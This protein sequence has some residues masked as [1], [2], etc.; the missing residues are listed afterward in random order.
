MKIIVI[1]ESSMSACFW[2]LFDCNTRPL[3]LFCSHPHSTLTL[4][5]KRNEATNNLFQLSRIFWDCFFLPA[6]DYLRT[7]QSGQHTSLVAQ[8]IRSYLHVKNIYPTALLDCGNSRYQPLP[9]YAT[10][11]VY[12][13]YITAPPLRSTCRES[14]PVLHFFSSLSYRVPHFKESPSHINLYIK[15]SH[16]SSFARWSWGKFWIDRTKKRIEEHTTSFSL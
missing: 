12:R 7:L 5:L 6:L 11:N 15:L 1:I 13:T 2:L 8:V 9:N 3:Y 14:P 10:Y 4:T 16:T